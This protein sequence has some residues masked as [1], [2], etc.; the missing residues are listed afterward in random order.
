MRSSFCCC[1]CAAPCPLAYT[2][3]ACTGFLRLACPSSLYFHCNRPT[4][5][6]L[7][8][9]G[10]DMGQAAVVAYAPAAAAALEGGAAED[11]DA[12]TTADDGEAA[13]CTQEQGPTAAALAGAVDQGALEA[14]LGAE[15]AAQLK[16]LG[17]EERSTF[18]MSVTLATLQVML[19]YEG[20]D[21]R[22][23]SQVRGVGAVSCFAH[24]PRHLLH[25]GTCAVVAACLPA[26]HAHSSGIHRFL[27]YALLLLLLLLHASG[28]DG[29]VWV[30]D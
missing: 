5:A 30:L 15:S 28:V 23:L 3:L 20:S 11:A 9:L 18:R 2:P 13:E 27:D 16:L 22:V 14:A 21:C 1:S 25:A 10:L 19:N 26:W 29:P 8:S 24:E 4:V 12:G 17:G 6:A 7:I